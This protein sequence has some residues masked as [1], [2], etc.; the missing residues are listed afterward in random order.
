MA[1]AAREFD[2]TYAEV[3]STRDPAFP[4]GYHADRYEID[5]GAGVA[6]FDRA[7]LGLRRWEAHRGAG[8]RV[9]PPEAVIAPGEVVLVA[10]G[11]PFA[12]MVAP[13]RIVYVTDE[14][15]RFGFAYGTVTGHPESGEESFHV[16]RTDS[17]A[18]FEVAAF[19]RAVHPLAR[20]GSPVARHLQKRVTNRY[21]AALR[22][23]VQAG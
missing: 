7:V 14:P 2:Y 17:G 16:V 6:V 15:N 23:F 3:G 19:S 11:L 13:C 9:A 10:L 22:D 5:L 21:L 1:A 18:R 12:S 8:A 20:L 4:P